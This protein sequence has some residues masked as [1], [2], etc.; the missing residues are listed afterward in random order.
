MCMAHSGDVLSRHDGYTQN[1]GLGILELLIFNSSIPMTFP[2]KRKDFSL[3]L[4]PCKDSSISH[5]EVHNLGL[6]IL[7]SYCVVI[8]D[9][10]AKIRANVHF[11]VLWF[12]YFGKA[13]DF[14]GWLFFWINYFWIPHVTYTVLS[15]SSHTAL[16]FYFEVLIIYGYVFSISYEPTY[17]P[18]YIITSYIIKG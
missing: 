10:W 17:T 12:L 16:N 4:T 9:V 3:I 6:K 15:E 11:A 8:L 5:T 14:C 13:Q 18:L 1:K 7:L 2:S